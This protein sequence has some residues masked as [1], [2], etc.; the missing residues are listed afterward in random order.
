MKVESREFW[1]LLAM[2]NAQLQSWVKWSVVKLII[3][4]AH[5]ILDM[6]ESIIMS[7]EE[8]G[9]IV[10]GEVSVSKGQGGLGRS[11]SGRDETLKSNNRT[12]IFTKYDKCQL[13][14]DVECD[15]LEN[16]KR[17]PLWQMKK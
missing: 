11:M 8:K 3:F 2:T 5:L 1:M 16:R 4:V 17:C 14:H 7:S 13:T 6:G 12:C 10:D 15:G 9:K